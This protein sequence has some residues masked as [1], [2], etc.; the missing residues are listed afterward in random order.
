MVGGTVVQLLKRLDTLLAAALVAFG[1]R[2]VPGRW[3]CA[4]MTCRSPRDAVVMTLFTITVALAIAFVFWRV[5]SRW[6]ARVLVLVAA[7]Y[8][9]NQLPVWLGRHG[10]WNITGERGSRCEVTYGM[11]QDE[12]RRRCGAPTYWCEGPKHIEALNQWNPAALFVCSFRGDVYGV[13]LITYGCAGGVDSVEAI[14]G[15]PPEKTRPAGCV[16]WG[17]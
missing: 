9:S 17:R 11:R 14:S 4:E 8:A 15:D 5:T 10:S 12:V 2:V 13:R 6:W 7:A 1:L 3:L 16:S